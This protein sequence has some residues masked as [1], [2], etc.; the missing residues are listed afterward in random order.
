M[1]AEID[2][3]YAE[4]AAQ[5]AQEEAQMQAQVQATGGLLDRDALEGMKYFL[6]VKRQREEAT[7]IFPPKVESKPALGLLGGYGSDEEDD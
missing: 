2:A 7:K 3:A 6:Q 5:E 1:Q 4:A